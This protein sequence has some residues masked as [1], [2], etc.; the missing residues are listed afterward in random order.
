MRQFF[1]QTQEQRLVWYP[2]FI[3]LGTLSY[4]LL[5]IIPFFLS[6]LHH[7]STLDI[8]AGKAP[9]V[10]IPLFIRTL[11]LISIAMIPSLLMY[12]AGV[13]L[14]SMWSIW[15]E[16]SFH[17]VIR[18]TGSIMITLLILW[19]HLSFGLKVFTWVSF[20]DMTLKN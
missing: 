17:T 12:C 13:V 10:S 18:Y 15:K 9:H 8:N 14:V 11:W 5:S 19:F 7:L 20:I 6:D 2:R 4:M 3:L 16:L 1:R